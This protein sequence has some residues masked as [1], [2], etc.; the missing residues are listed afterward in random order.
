MLSN[1]AVNDFRFL[2]RNHDTQASANVNKPALLFPS[3]MLGTRTNYPQNRT[4]ERLQFRNDFSYF[5]PDWKGTHNFQGGRRSRS[6]RL[7]GV[8][9]Q[10]HARR[11]HVHAEPQPN[12]LDPSTY[13]AATR[14]QQ[15]LGR[16]DTADHTSTFNV[17][18]QDDWQPCKKAHAQPRC[19]L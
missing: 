12:F 8:L 5:V 14:Y 7:H 9:R 1:R 17:Y 2:Y 15:G 13:P 4:E 16:F 3:A 19:A 6:R 10:H 11:V 18:L